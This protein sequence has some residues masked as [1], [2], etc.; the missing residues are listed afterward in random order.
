MILQL[1]RKNSDLHFLVQEH[2]KYKWMSKTEII[3][4]HALALI[5]YYEAHMKFT[6]KYEAKNQDIEQ[7]G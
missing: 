6:H 2:G 5:N 1:A 3:R 4:E 7:N